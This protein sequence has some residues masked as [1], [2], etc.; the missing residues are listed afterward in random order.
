MAE[1]LSKIDNE[2]GTSEIK[3]IDNVAKKVRQELSDLKNNSDDQDDKNLDENFYEIKNDTVELKLNTIKTYLESKKDQSQIDLTNNKAVVLAVQIAL[4]QFSFNPGKIDGIIG[5]KTRHA[6]EAF[7]KVA[8]I[9]GETDIGPNTI[10]AILENLY[11]REEDKTSDREKSGLLYQGN[12]ETDIE[13]TAPASNTTHIESTKRNTT[14]KTEKKENKTDSKEKQQEKGTLTIKDIAT[15]KETRKNKN[16]TYAITVNGIKYMFRG[17][18]RAGIVEFNKEKKLRE[19]K[20]QKNMGNSVDYIKVIK[21]KL[22]SPSLITIGDLSEMPSTTRNDQ[23]IR[24]DAYING[25]EYIFF[26]NGRYKDI[27]ASTKENNIMGNTNNLIT[28]LQK[29]KSTIEFTDDDFQTTKDIINGIN[30]SSEIINNAKAYGA[31]T[32]II[33]Y[34]KENDISIDNY[35]VSPFVTIQHT[36]ITTNN[37]SAG[38]STTTSNKELGRID[39]SKLIN[40]KGIFSQEAFLQKVVAEIKNSQLADQINSKPYI[41]TDFYTGEELKIVRLKSFFNKEHNTLNFGAE[42]K[43]GF[44]NVHMK[45]NNITYKIQ[46][47]L[48]RKPD[49]SFDQEKFKK[50]IKAKI[51]KEIGQID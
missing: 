1:T 32:E 3:E 28:S 15:F 9:T 21:E 36:T 51:N 25:K 27:Q 2:I 24:Y 11:E 5:E 10:N 35:S 48:L 6:I 8:N 14:E 4:K 50:I 46:A 30:I 31:N 41:M 39:I 16:L 33:K 20:D 47:I 40:N 18:G 22:K 45:E 44:I 13:Y 42:Y 43:N 19:V 34:L 38:A 26:S 49:G 29:D 7:K 23:N 12:E 17:N 37:T